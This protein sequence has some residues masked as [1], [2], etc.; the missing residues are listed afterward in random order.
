MGT[1]PTIVVADDHPLIRIGVQAALQDKDFCCVVGQ[2]SNGSQ[3]L[4][5]VGSQL[6]DLL[7]LDLELGPGS[8]ADELISACRERQPTLKVLIL[9]S[10]TDPR[11]LL[12]LQAL[13][14]DGFVVKSEAPDCLAQAVRV[15]LGGDK[16][17]SHE[18]ATLVARPSRRRESLL[19]SLTSREF[20]VLR[21]MHQGCDN[22]SIADAL[23]LSKDTIRR[24]VTIIYQKLGVQNRVEAI[25]SLDLCDLSLY[26]GTVQI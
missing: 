10:H 8:M 14:I 9:S 4:E 16:W 2:A 20:Q 3:V 24:Y 7:I 21:L 22:Q 23:A 17:F 1:L 13:D 11:R 19:D 5:L 25:L 26:S 18:V 12:P 15:V 6:P